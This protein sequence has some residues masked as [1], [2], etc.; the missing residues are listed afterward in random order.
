MTPLSL[1]VTP[2]QAADAYR[3]AEGAGNSTDAVG[4]FSA[5]LSRAIGGAIDANHA[6]E[7]QAMQAIAGGGNLTEVVTAVSKAQLALQTATTIRDRMVQAYQQ[8]MQMPI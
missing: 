8:I 4:G 2:S 3:A 1:T 6:A 7:D 5:T